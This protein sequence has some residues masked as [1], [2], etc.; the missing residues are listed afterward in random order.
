MNDPTIS[1]SSAKPRASSGKS[2]QQ[3]KSENTRLQ[4][5][6]ATLYCFSEYG[7]HNTTTEKVSKQARVS[8]GA[9]L[10][11][12]SQRAE[13]VRAAVEHLH[14]KRLQEY[15]RDLRA[16]NEDAKHTLVAEGIEVFGGSSNHHCSRSIVNCWL[17][18]GPTM[19]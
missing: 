2:W 1:S 13:L 4:I 6:E 11:H 19:S 7:F 16:L 10:H 17:Q 14:E 12:F 18:Q 3:T 5:L 15:E 8:R 9:M